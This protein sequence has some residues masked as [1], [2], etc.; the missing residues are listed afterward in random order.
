MVTLIT[1]DKG[2]ITPRLAGLLVDA[3]RAAGIPSTSAKVIQGS[4][5]RGVAAS[6][7]THDAGG[8]ADLSIA[9]LSSDQQVKLVVE[10]RRRNGCAWLRTPAYG[11]PASAGGPHLH[12]VIRDEP[13]LSAGAKS[14]VA[15]Y[16]KGLNGLAS[17]HRDTLPR[18]EQHSVETVRKLEAAKVAASKPGPTLV[19]SGVQ[20]KTVMHKTPVTKPVT[21]VGGKWYTAATI[22]IPKGGEY[23][24]TM[25]VRMPAKAADAECEL[26]RLGW[27]GLS[28]EDS[29]G[30]NQADAAHKMYGV[31]MRWRTPIQGHTIS[32]GGKLAFRILM[33]PGTHVTRFVCKATRVA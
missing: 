18:P 4:Y 13:G 1:V 9:G 10:L 30:H 5:N 11:W 28:K 7:G 29:T 23:A 32:G 25:Q 16:D 12:A 8:V 31:W 3:R 33:P 15:A 26:V 17:K 2:R 20:G 24:C 27:E 22:V 6:A 19:H 14:Q 21:V